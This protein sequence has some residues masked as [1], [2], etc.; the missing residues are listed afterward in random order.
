[1]VAVAPVAPGMVAEIVADPAAFPVTAPTELT[2]AI[3]G[4][5]EAQVTW[6]VTS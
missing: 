5:L 4:A 6:L 1:M 2:V 3:V